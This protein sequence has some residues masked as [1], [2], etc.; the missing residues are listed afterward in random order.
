MNEC[1]VKPV[2]ETNGALRSNANKIV[3]NVFIRRMEMYFLET[4]ER[5]KAAEGETAE[6]E[7][8]HVE[9]KTLLGF[10]FIHWTI[11]AHFLFF[12]GLLTISCIFGV[13]LACPRILDSSIGFVF[14][15][16]AVGVLFSAFVMHPFK[17]NKK[18]GM[19]VSKFFTKFKRIIICEGFLLL[20]IPSLLI[21]SINMFSLNIS[22]PLSTV[23][24]IFASVAILSSLVV[25]LIYRL[26]FW[27]KYCRKIRQSQAI[28]YSIALIS[29][30]FIVF[31]GIFWQSS[32]ATQFINI[33]MFE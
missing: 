33:K 25:N 22:Y 20:L 2:E 7:A 12:I 18:D 5:E 1:I 27:Y 32:F 3:K 8:V 17:Y 4:E 16:L 15:Y 13:V 21:L 31:L 19:Y 14:K 30:G 24:I 28:L 11:F 29:L 26:G 10:S 9:E 23:I 6:G